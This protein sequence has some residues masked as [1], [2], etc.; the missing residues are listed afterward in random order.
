MLFS[1]ETDS[2]LIKKKAILQFHTSRSDYMSADNKLK[3][4]QLA[5]LIAELNY[6]KS[7]VAESYRERNE[8]DTGKKESGIMSFFKKTD[9]N[10]RFEYK[11]YRTYFEKMKKELVDAEKNF[12]E[13]EKKYENSKKTL[14]AIE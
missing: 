9:P 11:K 8:A 5:V 4:A 13:S 6:E 1:K 12:K 2:K 7:K 14:E 3:S 10:D